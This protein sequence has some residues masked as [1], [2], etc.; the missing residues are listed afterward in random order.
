MTQVAA[1]VAAAV[2]MEPPK[3]ARPGPPGL[4]KRIQPP[5]Q[6]ATANALADYWG[7]MTR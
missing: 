2:G 3:H 7:P 6:A 5:K 4:W 1:A